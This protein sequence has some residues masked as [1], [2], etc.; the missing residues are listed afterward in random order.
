MSMSGDQSRLQHM[1]EQVEIKVHAGT[2]EMLE[3]QPQ[4]EEQV[5]ETQT[6]VE[7]ERETGEN[8]ALAAQVQQQFPAAHAEMAAPGAPVQEEVATKMT[9]KER[10]RERKHAEK[11]RAACPVG[12]AA[13]YD[14]VKQIS[15]LNTAKENTVRNHAEL[16]QRQ[17]VDRRVLRAFAFPYQVNKKG[18]PATKE[19]E[20]AK[21]Q[22]D[23]FVQD[24]CSNDLQRRQPH[25]E[26]IVNELLAVQC[27]PDMLSPQNLRKNAAQLRALGDK[28]VYLENLMRDPVNRPYFDRMDPVR[29]ERLEMSFETLYVPFVA[30]MTTQFQKNGVEPN[31]G[32]Y[33]GYEETAAIELGQN[34]GDQLL[35]E[36]CTGLRRRQAEEIAIAA[37]HVTR[38]RD[39]AQD[40]ARRMADNTRALERVKADLRL[41]LRP[42]ERTSPFLTQAVTL[43]KPGEEHLEENLEMVRTCLELGRVGHAARPTPALYQRAR[44]MLAPRVHRVLD[45]DVEHFAQMDDRALLASA[46]QLN[47]L[48]MDHMFVSDLMKLQHP[49][50]RWSNATPMTLRDDLVGQ[51]MVE[52]DYKVTLLRGLAD[53]ARGLAL[54]Q[55]GQMGPLPE[56]NY[57]TAGERHALAGKT[58]EQFIA[59][60]LELGTREIEAAKARY[61]DLRTPGTRAFQ[62]W[63][64]DLLMKGAMQTAV[65]NLN[66]QI[67]EQEFWGRRTPELDRVMSRV[68]DL[69]YF[70]LAYSPQELQEMGIPKDIGE[71]IFR[72][73]ASTASMEAVVRLMSPEEFRQMVLDLGAGGNL[74]Y[75]TATREQREAAVAQNARGLAAYKRVVRAQFD[76][77]ERRYGDR[78]EHITVRELCDYYSSL[79]LDFSNIQVL[80][81]MA[82]KYPGFINPDD[83]EDQLLLQQINYYVIIGGTA[84]AGLIS[85]LGGDV[86]ADADLEKRV[87]QTIDKDRITAQAAAY[88]K[89]NREGFQHKQAIDWNQKVLL[90]VKDV[91]DAVGR[92]AQDMGPMGAFQTVSDL[93][94]EEDPEGVVAQQVLKEARQ[95]EEE[96]G[97]DAVPLAAA[98]A[99]EQALR[100]LRDRSI[101]PRP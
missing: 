45:C 47:E 72:S 78:L 54:Q 15:R 91:G 8:A 49:Y 32:R 63:A 88:L 16:I 64:T 71:P 31:T 90:P 70:S 34:A 57:L 82:T 46:P 41:G 51:R 11:A 30:A 99:A 84:L 13:T 74:T 56:E 55:Q 43:M 20:A 50:Q 68:R 80:L 4:L 53:R 101:T 93:L 1:Q 29:R 27:S 12:T 75:E 100:R 79:A 7:T 76:M 6:P 23:L 66:F 35:N 73:F 22:S 19:D 85:V 40:Y 86:K 17:Q 36:F 96:S 21:Q 14:M 83:P 61:K 2:E 97:P 98:Y 77:M 67:M 18:Q 9:W 95:A 87:V 92:A 52:Y 28:M 69:H 37:R 5:R 62:E 44:D 58:V 38:V 25:L 33:F 24:Y 3:A 81:N 10:R 89:A 94:R 48:C 59:E 65:Y 42:E 60:R 26:R 39:C